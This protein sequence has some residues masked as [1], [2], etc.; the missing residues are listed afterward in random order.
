MEQKIKKC[1]QQATFSGIDPVN[2]PNAIQRN[3]ALKSL[4]E[5]YKRFSRF[6]IILAATLPLYLTN[7]LFN[8]TILPSWLGMLTVVT[9]S[10]YLLTA[11]I[12]DRWLCNGI[13][14][15]DLAQLT[16]AQACE[17]AL[18]YRKKHLQFILILLP[19]AAIFISLLAYA[20]SASTYALWGMLCGGIIGICIGAHKLH[21]FLTDY[22]LCTTP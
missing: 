4:A 8:H 22:H 20:L 16:V 17:R 12:M 19:F 15:I 1:W 18:Y 13:S 14:R 2:H 3:T 10:L 11:S 21:Q 9:G 6:S 7:L 5:R